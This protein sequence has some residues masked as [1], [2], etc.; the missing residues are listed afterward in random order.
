MTDFVEE[1][2]GLIRG[3]GTVA[4]TDRGP[5]RVVP[6]HTLPRRCARTVAVIE[7]QRQLVALGCASIT[8]EV[9]PCGTLVHGTRGD[10]VL[11]IFHSYEGRR[12]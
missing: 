3:R 12:P 2:V 1:L 4:M 11:Q 6:T 10:G 8:V 7:T 9:G 5:V